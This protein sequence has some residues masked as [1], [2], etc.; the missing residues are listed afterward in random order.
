MPW[1]LSAEYGNGG[2][3]NIFKSN[4]NSETNKIESDIKSHIIIDDSTFNKKIN[5]KDSNIKLS[6][7]INFSGNKVTTNIL[8]LVTIDAMLTDVNFVKNKNLRGSDFINK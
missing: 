4:F 1:K 5:I 3:I 8:D 2:K 6:K 7:K